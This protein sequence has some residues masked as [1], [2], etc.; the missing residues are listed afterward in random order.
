MLLVFLVLLKSPIQPKIFI[1][2]Y[3]EWFLLTK[4]VKLN[5]NKNENEK[6]KQN[7]KR[8]SL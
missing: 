8:K 2:I 3:M 7:K 1:D 5:K 6:Q 4:I